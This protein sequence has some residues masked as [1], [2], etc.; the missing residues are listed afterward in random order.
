MDGMSFEQLK[1]EFD[2]PIYD[3]DT[4]GLLALLA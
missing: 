3:L 2:V 1:S 4:D